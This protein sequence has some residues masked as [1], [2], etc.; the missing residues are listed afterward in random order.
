MRYQTSSGT[1]ADIAR[2]KPRRMLPVVDRD[3]SCEL[4]LHDGI[5]LYY[6]S[7]SRG[8]R[9][10]RVTGSIF[11]P[12]TYLCANLCPGLPHERLASK[13]ILFPIASRLNSISWS[14]MRFAAGR[15]H[16]V[17]SPPFSNRKGPGEAT[18]AKNSPRN[19]LAFLSSSE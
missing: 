7:R 11:F 19:T 14:V 3:R 17:S 12:F 5:V 10:L 9:V 16:D 18:D 13:A 1:C 15:F 4:C 2:N 8:N 6:T